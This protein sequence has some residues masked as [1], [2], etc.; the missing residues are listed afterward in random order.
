MIHRTKLLCTL[1]L[2]P[3]LASAK[4]I[5]SG[6]FD[7]RDFKSPETTFAGRPAAEVA[8]MC[9]SGEHAS[10]DDLGQCSHLKFNRANALMEQKLRALTARIR[11]VDPSLKASGEPTALPYFEKAQSAW[12]SYRDSECYGETYSM[13]EASERYIFFWECMASITERRTKEL[14]EVLNN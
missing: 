7:Y 10:N 12:A 3:I 4:T 2:L 5:Y 13:G 14:E 8:R 9:E 1:A 11:N 6:E